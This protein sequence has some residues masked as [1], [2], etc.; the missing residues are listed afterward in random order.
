MQTKIFT[1]FIALVLILGGVYGLT[2][3]GVIPETAGIVLAALVTAAAAYLTS[4]AVTRPLQEVAEAATDIAGGDLERRIRFSG[5]DPA[6]K[7]AQ[8]LNKL[9]NSLRRSLVEVTEERN[10]MQAILDSMADGMIALDGEGRVMALNPVMEK[11]F[12]IS[13]GIVRGKPLLQAVRDYELERLWREVLQTGKP[14]KQE[15]RL[16]TPEPRIFSAHLTP[17]KGA[18]GGVVAI[19]RDIT[20]R[21]R[22]E[23]LRTEFIANVSHEL[24][25]PLTSIR[26]FVET[27]M[28]EAVDDPEVARRFL[29]IIDQ[30]AA[31]LS[32]LVE[33]MLKLGK[34][35]EHQRHF[36]RVPVDVRAL[37][38]RAADVFSEQ[39]AA[40][41]LT[42][43]VEVPDELPLVGGEADLLTQVL[44]N[45]LSNALKFTDR[46]AIHLKAWNEEDRVMIEVRD[47]GIGIPE[48][49]LPR[50]FERFYRVDRARAAGR[51]GTG[52]GL[53]IVKH[54]VEGHGGQVS[55]SSTVG[56]GTSFTVR[57]PALSPS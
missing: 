55:V 38:K 25:T 26:G 24:R 36:R 33:E 18:E 3:A 44:D 32:R 7:L 52:L 14:V 56:K 43:E 13:E 31:R 10:R 53:A 37:V 30:E 48:E 6:G 20:E 1:G 47:T 15:L 57:L 40:R 5:S 35:E 51:G 12:G 8:S 45:L 29:G 50:I 22:L 34:I 4:R 49:A 16:L 2:R 9:A 39:A 54:V 11:V 23:R 46:G 28:D 19:L 21:R 27:L 41:G 42:L 17:L